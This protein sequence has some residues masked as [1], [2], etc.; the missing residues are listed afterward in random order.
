MKLSL[1][2]WPPGIRIDADL[3]TDKGWTGS[4]ECAQVEDLSTIERQILMATARL[5][6][7]TAWMRSGGDDMLPPEPEVIASHV[8]ALLEQ[9]FPDRGFRV[10]I[11]R[12]RS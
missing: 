12:T 2:L 3:P 1:S 5:F 9:S 10:R 11:V 7:E 6:W 4:I 8:E